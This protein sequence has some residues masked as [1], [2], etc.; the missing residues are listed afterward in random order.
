MSSIKVLLWSFYVVGEFVLSKELKS[1]LFY[2]SIIC[3]V[4]SS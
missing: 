1:L 4:P 2:F 3:N